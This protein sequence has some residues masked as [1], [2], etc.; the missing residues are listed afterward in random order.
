MFWIFFVTQST[1]PKLYSSFDWVVVVVV[2]SAVEYEYESLS[3]LKED[4]VDND[5]AVNGSCDRL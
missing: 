1:N 4:T 2:V 5:S 3:S